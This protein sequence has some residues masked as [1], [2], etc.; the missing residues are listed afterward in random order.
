MSSPDSVARAESTRC[1]NVTS[2][3]RRLALSLALAGTPLA[4]SRP[5][6]G[7][8]AAP[9][10]GTQYSVAMVDVLP[11][12]A[13]RG[14]ALLTRYADETRAEPGLVRLDLVRQPEPLANH[15]A[16]LAVWR[17]AS[18]RSAHLEHGFVR[19]F[20]ENL[21]PLLASPLDDRVYMAVER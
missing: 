10:S 16:L 2:A 21:H 14:A 20:R 3:L 12:E 9:D 8:P 17:S 13:E 18:D 19:R 5:S 15:F 4:A 1:R 7:E 6:S 11:S